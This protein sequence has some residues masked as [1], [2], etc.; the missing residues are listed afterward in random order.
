MILVIYNL[1]F[2]IYSLSFKIYKENFTFNKKSYKVSKVICIISPMEILSTLKEILEL[3]YSIILN[4]NFNKENFS[5]IKVTKNNNNNTSNNNI[6]NNNN[7]Q[8]SYVYLK[9]KNN[10]SYQ[11]VFKEYNLLEFYFGFLLNSLILKKEEKSY[12][13]SHIG[14][15]M[16]KKSFLNFNINSQ[17]F[18]KIK[19][20]DITKLLDIINIE[21]LIKLYIGILLEYKIILIFEDYETINEIIFSLLSIIYP[22]KWRLPVIS[23]ILESLLDSL[24]APFGMICGIN[25]KFLPILHKK[26]DQ[27]LIGEETL[28]FNIVNNSF[29]YL[30]INLP[31]FPKKI[32]NEIKH[33]F[34]L[35]QAEKLSLSLNNQMSISSISGYGYGSGTGKNKIY[36]NEMIYCIY[37]ESIINKINPMIYISLKFNLIFIR[38]F[39]EIFNT[40]EDFIDPLLLNELK[41]ELKNNPNSKN[42]FKLSLIFLNF[43]LFSFKFN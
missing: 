33:N 15:N 13:I 35:I 41:M 27:K 31:E 26:I 28:I 40:I 17:A 23:Y 5:Q 39:I 32:T 12:Y 19:D 34:Y 22:L 43:Y 21:H 29:V 24:E 37:P 10:N 2:N 11:N 4:K 1:L 38:S 7:T 9:H 36:N 3:I 20:Y 6:I 30:P 42:L 16:G 8:I 14:N 18:L 25:T